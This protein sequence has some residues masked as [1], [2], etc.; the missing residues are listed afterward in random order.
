MASSSTAL[1]AECIEEDDG[2]SEPAL[3][4]AHVRDIFSH[5]EAGAE[6]ASP[7]CAC[8]HG[9]LTPLALQLTKLVGHVSLAA[10]CTHLSPIV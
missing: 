3:T 1:D 7:P 5:W 8:R 10:C 2:L 9:C 4:E 6:A